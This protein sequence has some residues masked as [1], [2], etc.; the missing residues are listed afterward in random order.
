MKHSVSR[1]YSTLSNT[2]K[3]PDKNKNP[4]EHK[5]VFEKRLEMGGP[6]KRNPPWKRLPFDGI[7]PPKGTGFVGLKMAPTVPLALPFCQ[8]IIIQRWILIQP[9]MNA[10]EPFRTDNKWYFDTYHWKTEIAMTKE[11]GWC[12]GAF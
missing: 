6:T 10:C 1:L 5:L 7:L 11:C 2:K 4:F 12:F 3:Y 9:I 8:T